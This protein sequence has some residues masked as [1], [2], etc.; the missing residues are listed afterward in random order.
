MCG[1]VG[2][3]RAVLN[4][5]V[6]EDDPKQRKQGIHAKDA[7]RGEEA[8]AS[9]DRGGCARRGSDEAKDEP[10]L[11]A[12]F[13]SHPAG[14]GGDVRQGPTQQEAPE[15]PARGVELASPEIERS[16]GHE[17]AEPSSEADHDVV[18]VKQQRQGGRP[19][20][21]GKVIEALDFSGGGAVDEEAEDLVDAKRIVDGLRLVIGL[22]HDDHACALF[23]VEE[24]FHG[25]DG[26]GL[27]LRHVLAVEVA[28]GEDLQYAGDDAG[29][30]TELEKD[31]AEGTLAAV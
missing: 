31:V 3:V 18:A 13:S 30:D 2:C 26:G 9:A 29:D 17:R 5:V 4:V 16:D 11:T 23:R 19:L 25:C 15:N 6:D 8:V 21:A 12:D 24:A 20:V 28:G 14:S 27:V 10:G 7:E 1:V 22:A